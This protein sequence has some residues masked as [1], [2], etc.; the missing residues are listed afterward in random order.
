MEF[1]SL[2]NRS[3]GEDLQGQVSVKEG[4]GGQNETKEQKER[5]EEK[6]YS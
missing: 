6:R 2:F 4:K 3:S 1:G 5:K